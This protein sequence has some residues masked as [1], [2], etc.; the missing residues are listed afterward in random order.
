MG[1]NTKIEW[2]DHS[3]NPWLGCTKVSAG[4]ANCYAEQLM[5]GRFGKVQWGPQGTRKRTSAANWR[6]PLQ[7]NKEQWL[8]CPACGWRGAAV[9][10]CPDCDRVHPNTT[11]QRVFCASLADIF[12]D[13]PELV[14]WRID[15]FRLIHQTKNLDWLLL[16]KRPE[17]VVD[18]AALDSPA[19][20]MPDNV[21]IGTSVE[22]QEQ[23]DKR[24]PELLKIP[25]TVR[26]LS[27]EPL[28]GPVDL[29]T[30]GSYIDPDGFG[31]NGPMSF[32][33]GSS[34]EPDNPIDWVIV[35]GESGP[36]ARP[37]HPDW[38]RSIRDQCQAAGV[39]FF[40]KQ[41]GEYGVFDHT[42]S[43]HEASKESGYLHRSGKYTKFSRSTPPVTGKFED[44]AMMM[45]VGKK[46]AGRLLDGVEWSEFPAIAVRPKTPGS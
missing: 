22:D 13:R 11:R 15:L 40:F 28:L 41:W 2:C 1:E 3:W 16:T 5:D 29:P 36:N 35:G 43:M 37:M 10:I 20:K 6:K 19:V 9:S 32:Q 38:V 27:I 34:I 12:E 26:F 44:L 14:E 17:N 31:N 8:E 39:P 30:F 33:L 18:M 4:C 46:A 21:W 45:K 42:V 23:A 7:W 24:I 25:A